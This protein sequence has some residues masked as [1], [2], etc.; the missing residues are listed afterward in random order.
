MHLPSSFVTLIETGRF[1]YW[2]DDAQEEWSDGYWFWTQAAHCTYDLPPG[3]RYERDLRWYVPTSARI[4]TPTGM[5]PVHDDRLISAALTAEAD[6]LLTQGKINL[7]QAI[8]T[9]IPPSDPLQN[10]SF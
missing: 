10:L 8:S 7:G 6:R 2:S 3:A 1:K 4:S 9:I 5:L